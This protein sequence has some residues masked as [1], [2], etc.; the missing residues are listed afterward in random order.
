MDQD[1]VEY[2]PHVVFL[3]NKAGLQD[4]TPAFIEKVKEFYNKAFSGS[5]LQTHSGID[6]N[7]CS[8]E[9]GFNLFLIPSKSNENNITFHE[10]EKSLINKLRTKIYGVSKGS[11]TPSALTEK[12]WYHYVSKV[13][14]AIKKS[15]L[16]S[17]YGRLMP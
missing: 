9:N 15:H 4:F 3:H 7:H 11:M 13:M 16:S 6:M 10:G 5:R 8:V 14:E 1:Y 2:Y 17:E 12:H